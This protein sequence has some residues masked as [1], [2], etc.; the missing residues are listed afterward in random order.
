MSLK[1]L[2]LLTLIVAASA[3]PAPTG[4]LIE[5][6]LNNGF[7]IEKS[8]LGD[9]IGSLLGNILGATNVVKNVL[10]EILN[11]KI[12]V[13]GDVITLGVKVGS[14]LVRIVGC[15]LKIVVCFVGSAGNEAICRNDWNT[16]FGVAATGAANIQALIRLYGLTDCHSKVISYISIST[17][18]RGYTKVGGSLYLVFRAIIKLAERINILITG[19]GSLTK[20]DLSF[21]YLQMGLK[22]INSFLPTCN[23]YI[24]SAGY[25]GFGDYKGL[26]DD[27]GPCNNDNGPW[28]ITD[29]SANGNTGASIG[30]GQL[31]GNVLNGV[32]GVSRLA[33]N[34]VSDIDKIVLSCFDD[35][36]NL[37][38][39]IILGLGGLLDSIVAGFVAVLIKI[40]LCFLGGNGNKYGVC[41]T[42]WNNQFGISGEASSIDTLITLYGV[43]DCKK[44]MN[45]FINDYTNGKGLESTSGSVRVLLQ[46]CVTLSQ[47]V[48]SRK[49]DKSL[50]VLVF[51][52][53]TYLIG[54][55]GNSNVKGSG[56]QLCNQFIPRCNKFLTNEGYSGFGDNQQDI[57]D[58]IKQG[59]GD[60]Y[61]W[62]AD[63][64]PAANKH[65]GFINNGGGSGSVSVG[66]DGGIIG[67][68]LGG[69]FGVLRGVTSLAAGV[70]RDIL[71]ISE[72]YRTFRHVL[73]PTVAGTEINAFI[74]VLNLVFKLSL[75][76][77]GVINSVVS[78]LGL[79]ISRV[80][81]VIF[82]IGIC[83]NGFPGDRS[84]C[85]AGWN[86]QFGIDGEAN[87]AIDLLIL[88]KV[89]NAAADCNK[90]ISGY[91]NG[92]D[93]KK[94]SK[95]T[96]TQSFVSL[97]TIVA[98]IANANKKDSGLEITQKVIPTC[99]KYFVA[100]GYSGKDTVKRKSGSHIKAFITF[101]II[102]IISAVSTVGHRPPP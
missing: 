40:V 87:T 29:I 71:S 81:A 66:G 85:N 67:G 50:L 101:I 36:I 17:Q 53:L 63:I 4:P 88:F 92:R 84:I 59:N 91:N 76:I 8:S 55:V 3:S 64:N 31:V 83:V 98:S 78:G 52:H 2:V 10:T 57:I 20:A 69:I 68:L 74:D 30:L 45:V 7:H 60:S 90:Y 26:Q 19:S 79:L 18:G 6:I 89:Q 13:F 56:T 16:Q 100:Q 102:I 54:A 28:A 75:G 23:K 49:W 37:G 97:T 80:I 86:K 82:K 33:V 62:S 35:V 77:G 25:P 61:L 34:L 93:Y 96:I 70:V 22:I 41:R 47:V 1:V 44:R 73:G 11:L 24:V 32:L 42:G 21:C 39:K 12:R 43:R 58:V 9:T 38:V 15:F 46:S 65:V 72:F 14:L 51:R 48:E 95:E 27:I 99:G 5:G 94:I